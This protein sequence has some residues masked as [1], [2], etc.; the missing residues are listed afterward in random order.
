MF[1]KKP[2]KPEPLKRHPSKAR[3]SAPVFSYYSSRSAPHQQTASP[4]TRQRPVLDEQRSRSRAVTLRQLGA[5]APSLMALVVL[6]G[7]G[8]YLSTLNP[9]PRVQMLRAQ[10]YLTTAAYEEGIADLQA[11][12]FFN[13]SKLLVSTK[14]L[15][16]KIRDAYPELGE[17]MVTIPLA[18][19]RLIIE[20]VPARPV[21]LLAG[22]GETLVVDKNGRAILTAREAPSSMKDNIPVLQ[23]QSGVDL[24]RGAYV[25]PAT[26]VRFVE[27]VHQQF[28]SAGLQPQ[29][30]V[31]PAAPHELHVSL[32]DKDYLIKFDLT[33][34]GSLQ[35]GAFKALHK[36][37]AEESITP[38]QYVDVRVP[39]RA[40]YK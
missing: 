4:V 25:L 33:G 5:Y 20:A 6:F 27:E 2:K 23:D 14:E 30:Y 12:S 39:G 16:Q 31:L 15:E 32:K 38:R 37:L 28:T 34:E 3:S 10:S 18:S 22:T 19:R 29:S 35:A 21:L 40:F 1:R 9:R 8:V 26:A 36:H 17:V 13:R 11:A 7:C 24:K